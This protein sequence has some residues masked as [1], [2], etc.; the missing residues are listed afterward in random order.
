MTDINAHNREI[1]ANL[2][3]WQQKPLLREI[4]RSFYQSIASELN[5]SLSGH[6]VE[7]G[8]GVTD[9]SEIIPNCIRTDLFPNA[10]IDQVEN[11]YALSFDDHSVANLI[12]FDVFHHLRYPGTA[13]KEFYRVLKPG[14]R[15]ILFEPCIS[16]L[17]RI[18]YG[19]LHQE[20]VG[21]GQAI[22]WEADASWNPEAI[23][24]YAAQGNAT[25]IFVKRETDISPLG[26]SV[27]RIQRF[28][29]LSYVASGG[30]SKPQ[31]YP[32]WALPLMRSLDSLLDNFPA[33][34]AT[35]LLVTLEKADQSH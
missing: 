20:P 14:S 35:R 22:D 8:S 15:V 30:Y 19:L 33:C 23:D 17:G 5:P 12:L 27:R 24:Y 26:W 29:A 32:T 9:I 10:W 6:I 21:Y 16:A 11:A 7:L 25:R 3:N 34:F 18:V 13:L 2:D 28:S 31:L 1:H 4:Y